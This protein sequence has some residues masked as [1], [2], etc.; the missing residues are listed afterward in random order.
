MTKICIPTASSGGLDDFVGEHF[1]RVPTYTIY[2]SETGEVKVVDNTSEHMGGRGLPGSILANLGI[3]ILLCSGLG[4]RAIGIL[5]EKGIQIHTGFTGTAK[6]ALAAWK[7]G[8]LTG[9]SED[10]ACQ[11]HAFHDRH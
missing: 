1:G 5:N 9:A 4:R 6:E 2:D 8:G 10:D 7:G 3:D 11:K